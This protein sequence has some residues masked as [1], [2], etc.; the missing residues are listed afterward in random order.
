MHPTV[1]PAALVADAIRDCTK[2]GEIVLDGFGGSG[3]TLIAAGKCGQR[4][5]L[6]EYDPPIATPSSHDGKR[7]TGKQAT[8]AR[9]SSESFEDV[10]ERRVS[11][12][13]APDDVCRRPARATM[14]KIR[15]GKRPIRSATANHPYGPVH[16]G[17]T[18]NPRGRPKKS[19]SKPPVDR[20][21]RD[22][23]LSAT[24]RPVTIREGDNLQKIPLVDAIMRA[25]SVAALKGNTHAQKNFLER[26]A[27]FDRKRLE[28]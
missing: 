14:R 26:E 4:E 3:T 23:F 18:G 11:D 24:E 13:A 10:M 27:P 16:E 19:P 15:S 17:K 20:S 1:K 7:L 2:R 9:T 25:E 6:I 8:H 5:R 21:T 22:R 28:R 12:V